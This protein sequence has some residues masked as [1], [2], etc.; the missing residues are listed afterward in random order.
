M[1]TPFN[2]RNIM[3]TGCDTISIHWGRGTVAWKISWVS[4]KKVGE[5]ILLF[6]IFLIAA[7][8]KQFLCTSW[9][10]WKKMCSSDTSLHY[11]ILNRLSLYLIIGGE[12]CY[13]IGRN[14]ADVWVWKDWESQ[15]RRISIHLCDVYLQKNS[16]Y[17][18][19]DLTYKRFAECT[20][21]A[22][23]CR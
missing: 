2:V 1:R 22:K 7:F 13:W 17:F 15:V 11:S 9:R 21:T 5:I 4:P 10:I 14:F 12:S 3:G 20:V 16:F 18:I 6:N 8:I 19:S 23:E